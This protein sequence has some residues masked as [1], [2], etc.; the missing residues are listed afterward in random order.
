LTPKVRAMLDDARET[1]LAIKDQLALWDGEP[2]ELTEPAEEDLAR[3]RSFVE[4]SSKY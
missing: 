4:K 2:V 3:A 1:L